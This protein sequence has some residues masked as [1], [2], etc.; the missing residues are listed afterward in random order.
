MSQLR[1]NM[2]FEKAL[3][4]EGVT[5]PMAQLARS[6]YSQES[7]GG[8]NTKTSNAGAV[9]GMQIIPGTFKSMADKGWDINNPEHNAR[10]GIRYI[11]NLAQKAG[12]D[13]W[14][15]AVGYYSGEGGMNAAKKGVARVDRRN[16]NAPNTFQ[17]ADSVVGRIGL[18]PV[19][20][21]Y[22]GGGESMPLPSIEDI[23]GT[24]EEAAP[25]AEPVPEALP[26]DTSQGMEAFNAV[27]ANNFASGLNKQTNRAIRDGSLG[28]SSL[29]NAADTTYMDPQQNFNMGIFKRV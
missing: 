16:P 7:G 10:A 25:I 29:S 4:A 26:V 9:G 28:L 5:G 3:Q 8:R 22:A 14:L 19:G 21:Q 23:W 17:Y 11:K 18:N 6:I 13:P 24:P 20:Q 27:L 2:T 15:T 12:G 1:T